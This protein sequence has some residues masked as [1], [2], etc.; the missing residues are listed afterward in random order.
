MRKAIKFF[1]KDGDL[2][3]PFYIDSFTNKN[4][5][6][7]D[8]E[9]GLAQTFQPDPKDTNRQAFS[10][11]TLKDPSSRKLF[12]ELIEFMHFLRADYHMPSAPYIVGVDDEYEEHNHV[13]APAERLF[14]RI[15]PLLEIAL[16]KELVKTRHSPYFN[17]FPDNYIDRAINPE[18]RQNS[19]KFI[20]SAYKQMRDNGYTPMEIQN[21]VN[22]YKEW[23]LQIGG[24]KFPADRPDAYY[25]DVAERVGIRDMLNNNKYFD[26]KLDDLINELEA[27]PDMESDMRLK[28]IAP[29][30]KGVV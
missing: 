26:V 28:R 13:D 19:K 10:T 8:S 15:K 23:L 12:K 20:K 6:N 3:R 5:P 18:N 24:F 21:A 9:L 22:T 16:P 25:L 4:H 29:M 1:K 30:L 14:R 11:L 7:Y 2:L 17:E 27:D